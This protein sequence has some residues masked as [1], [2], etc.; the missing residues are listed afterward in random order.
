[1]GEREHG[2]G[3]QPREHGPP[4]GEGG[5]YGVDVSTSERRA[6]IYDT[7]RLP[8]D[9]R[10]GGALRLL[11]QTPFVAKMS[12]RRVLHVDEILEAVMGPRGIDLARQIRAAQDVAPRAENPVPRSETPC[13]KK[14]RSCPSSAHPP[15]RRSRQRGPVGRPDEPLRLD[16]GRGIVGEHFFVPSRHAT[17]DVVLLTSTSPISASRSGVMSVTTT[18]TAAPTPSRRHSH[19]EAGPGAGTTDMDVDVDTNDGDKAEAKVEV[20]AD[21]LTSCAPS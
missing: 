13:T 3:G 21:C 4:I 11:D 7:E 2:R 17:V 19:I 14:L 9:I 8:A 16:L 20:E 6:S 18:A 5:E 15:L 10:I 1:V 12:E